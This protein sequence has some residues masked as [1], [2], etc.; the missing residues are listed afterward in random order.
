MAKMPKKIVIPP[1]KPRGT[2]TP[3]AKKIKNP[4]KEAL[5]RACRDKVQEDEEA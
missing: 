2:P 3:P 5:K 4:K 1:L